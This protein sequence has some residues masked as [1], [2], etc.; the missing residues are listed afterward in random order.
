MLLKRIDNPAMQ[1]NIAL[2]IARLRGDLP[3][4]WGSMNVEQMV[5]HLAAAFRMAL[6]EREVRCRVGLMNG[7]FGR[8]VVLYLPV[9][10]IRGYPTLPELDAARMEVCTDGFEQSKAELSMLIERFCLS[11]P[12]QLLAEHPILGKMSHGEWMRWGY[13]HTDHHLRQFG[14]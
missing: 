3:A 11:T 7:P 1:S 8:F 6:K 13:L 4:R 2:R 9:R 12:E 5:R 14:C 10:W